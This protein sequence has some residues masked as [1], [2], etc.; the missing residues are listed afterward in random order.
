MS[1][2]HWTYPKVSEK[3]FLGHHWAVVAISLCFITFRIGVRIKYFRRIWA[4]DMLIMAAWI[5]ILVTACLHQIEGTNLYNQ[6]PLVTGKLSPTPEHLAGERSLLR[7]ELAE[8]FLFYTALW[9]V[10][11]SILVFFRRVF[12]DRQQIPWL[13][14]WWWAI[15]GFTIASWAA[16]IGTMPYSCLLKP[17]PYILARCAVQSG[18]DYVWINLRLSC[19]TDIVTDVLI[20]SLPV[21]GLWNVQISLRKKL[22]LMGIFSLTIV[23]ILF[24]IIRIAVEPNETASTDMVW[25]CLWAWVE[26]GVAVIVS[27]LASFRQ[28]FLKSKDTSSRGKQM[29]NSKTSY[30]DLCLS[31]DSTT[32][33]RVRNKFTHKMSNPF[34]NTKSSSGIRSLLPTSQTRPGG[35]DPLPWSH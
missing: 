13:R 22:A 32:W 34:S 33:S 11:L 9:C 21:L 18:I 29:P 35:T 30:D 31:S 20:L 1:T 16:C 5:M 10:K 6:Y 14:T 28:L 7:A 3:V 12:G 26:T 15:T 19:A 27:C 8:F 23:T 17:L 25:L 2:P 24:A 4:D